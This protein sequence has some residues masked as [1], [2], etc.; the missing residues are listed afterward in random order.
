MNTELTRL[1]VTFAKTI[2][3]MTGYMSYRQEQQWRALLDEY[4]ALEVV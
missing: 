2:R 1:N 3:D 4:R